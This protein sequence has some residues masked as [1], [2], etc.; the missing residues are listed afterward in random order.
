MMRGNAVLSRFLSINY[1][2]N[3]VKIKIIRICNTYGLRMQ[4]NDGRVVSNFIVQALKGMDLTIY[5]DG[6]QTRSFFYVDDLIEGMIFMMN[7]SDEVTGP[8]NI[9]IPIEFTMLELSQK[10]IKL[11]SSRSKIV[12]LELQVDD[13][14]QRKPEILMAQKNLNWNPSI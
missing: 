3:N 8:I 7:S 6:T 13:P 14:T 12:F 9:G 4:P 2:Q 1:H 10:V 5:R 11:T